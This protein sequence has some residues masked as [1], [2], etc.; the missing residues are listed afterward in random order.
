MD[1]NF[2]IIQSKYFND[3]NVIKIFALKN[4]KINIHQNVLRAFNIL[5]YILLFPP[6]VEVLD[7]DLANSQRQGFNLDSGGGAA[8]SELETIS[9]PTTTM[10]PLAS[11]KS[12]AFVSSILSWS[13]KIFWV[14]L[15]ST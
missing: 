14:F 15:F 4:F 11:V 8:P 7:Q 1:I 9:T 5:H 3:F 10:D 6:V 2:K 12:K 13:V